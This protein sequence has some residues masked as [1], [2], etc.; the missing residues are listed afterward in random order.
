M[1]RLSVNE[2]TTY[3]WSFEEDVTNYS[4]AGFPA[5][6]VW[7]QKLS[8]FGDEKGIELLSEYQLQVSSLLWA[9]GFTGSDGRT[10]A[11]S[12]E[13][14]KEA[15]WLAD[16]LNAQSL[17]I[18]TGARGG[19]THKHARRLI[20]NA[21]DQLAPLATDIDVM[22]AVEPMH[23]GCATDWTFLTDL[24][25]A[26][27]LVR[28]LQSSHVK[29]VL[30][31]YHFGHIHDLCQRLPEL[32]SDIALVHLGDSK[33]PPVNG[34]QNRCRLGE[35]NLPLKEITETLNESGYDGWYD[36]EL[37]GEEIEVQDY[38]DLLNH[39]K[40]AFFELAGAIKS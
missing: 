19:H 26:G 20:V 30:D 8:D 1:H 28:S 6:G 40:E 34:E 24:N 18:Y 31:T 29:L 23:P 38:H 11:E 14:A 13:D 21:L 7:R 37:M 22:L 36:V 17:V 39:S 2:M 3:R 25:E 15:L 32:I 35:G 16:S 9:G 10:H 33:G 4:A 12:I 27:N 5:L